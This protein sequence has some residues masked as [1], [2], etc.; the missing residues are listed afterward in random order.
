MSEATTQITL[1]GTRL[2]T[3]GMEFVFNGP[4]TECETCK[5]RNTCTNLERG[6]RYRVLGLRGE[7]IHECP[8]HDSGVK[9]VEVTE[10]P[11]IVAIDVRKAFAGSKMILEPPNCEEYN[12]SMYEICHPVGLKEGDRCTI[13]DVVGEAPEECP[14]GHSLK[15]VEL[16][17]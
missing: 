3:I 7:L 13:V 2:A 15:L 17:R 9:A 1:I 16:R 8:L 5:L 12:C 11:I 4:T 10:S 14:Q 6:R